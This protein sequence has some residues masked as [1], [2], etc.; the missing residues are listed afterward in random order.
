M[1]DGLSQVHG[2]ERALEMALGAGEV[3][4]GGTGR[5]TK[6]PFFHISASV[7]PEAEG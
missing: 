2:S 3:G 4:G 7:S 5:F 1:A 6:Q